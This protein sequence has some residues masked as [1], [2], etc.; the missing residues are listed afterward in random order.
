MTVEVAKELVKVYGRALLEDPERLGQ[1]LED[2]CGNARREI[3]IIS[4]ALK[5][6]ARGGEVPS[7]EKFTEDRERIIEKLC[8]NLGFAKESSIWAVDAISRILE[9]GSEELAPDGHIEAH[10]GFLESITSG[11]AKRPRTAPFRKKTLRNGLLLLCIIMSFLVLFVTITESR[12]AVSNEHR[13]LFLAH[14]SGTDAASGHVRLKAAQMAA[15]QINAEGGVRGRPIHIL[16]YDIQSSPEEAAEV[17]DGLLREKNVAAVISACSDSVNPAIA[18]VADKRETPLIL[19]ESSATSATMSAV[20]RPWLYTFRTNFDNPYR[21]RLLAYFLAHGLK[22]RTVALVSE[23]YDVDSSEMRS[24]F[25]QWNATYGGSILCEEVY[26]KRGGLDRASIEEII[27]SGADAVV[28]ANHMPDIAPLLQSLRAYG[29]DGVVLG[30]AYDESMQIAGG[31][32]LDNS[33]WIVPASPDD[34]QLQSYQA[35]YRNKYNESV[36][37]SD[38]AGTLLAYDAVRWMADALNRSPDFRGEALRHSFMSTKNMP[39][40]HATLSIDPRSHGPWNKSASLVYCSEGRGR[41]QKR[42]RPE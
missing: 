6:I 1:L 5:E 32:A 10:S 11:I 24:S 25:K 30:A 2:E 21:G 16:G 42:F 28:I 12:Y 36:F 29:Y 17:L 18:K 37:G 26:T 41:F 33:W 14:L 13:I 40:L 3:F 7:F 4:F 38:F 23:A 27:S 19:T 15:D 9:C 34:P 20:D 39:L 31:E 22:R 35:L 8:R